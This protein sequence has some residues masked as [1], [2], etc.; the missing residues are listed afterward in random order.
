M[1]VQRVL[2]LRS[3]MMRGDDVKFVQQLLVAAG[4]SP[5][6]VDG[7]FGPRTR[8][9]VRTFQRDKGLVPDGIVGSLTWAALCSMQRV[10]RLLS[11]MMRGEDVRLAQQLLVAA[12]HSP[13]SVDGVFG[14][15]TS[16]AVRA[17][18]SSTG[19][20]PDGIVGSLT[21]AALCS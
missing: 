3:P 12:G 19:L 20:D 4:H 11:P 14:P 10:L 2:R 17:F 8:D 9:A 18:Q 7:V 5:G 15:R 13:G 21:W 16:K 1:S 6:S